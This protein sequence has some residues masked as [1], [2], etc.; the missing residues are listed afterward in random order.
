MGFKKRKP[1]LSSAFENEIFKP[2]TK[3]N[4]RCRLLAVTCVLKSRPIFLNENETCLWLFKNISRFCA[5]LLK[6]KFHPK[7]NALFFIPKKIFMPKKKL[8]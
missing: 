6:D 7:S 8:P 2:H 1:L 3:Q 5:V 4:L